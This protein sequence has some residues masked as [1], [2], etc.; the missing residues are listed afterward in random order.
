MISNNAYSLI[1]LSIV[2]LS[3]NIITLNILLFDKAYIALFNS[4]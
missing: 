1:Y 3:C 2:S 4:R